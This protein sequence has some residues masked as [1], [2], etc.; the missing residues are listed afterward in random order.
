MK[1]VVLG[2]GNTLLADEGAGVYAMHYLRNHYTLPDTEFIDGGTLSF[3]LAN[4]IAEATN[5]IIF[6]AAE[7]DAKPGSVRVFEGAEFDDFLLSGCRSV[8]EVGFADLMDI[9][10]LLDTMPENYALVGIQPGYLGW[11][12][13]PGKAVRAAT[14]EAAARAADLIYEWTEPTFTKVVN[15]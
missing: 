12:D 9:S 8:H 14:P 6:D 1:T 3:M 4:A 2:V 10:R 13:T 11:D 5:L 15:Q 7:L